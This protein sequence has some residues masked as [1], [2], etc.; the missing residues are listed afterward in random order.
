M[1]VIHEHH[2]RDTACKQ[3]AG[4]TEAAIAAL[5]D[6][7]MDDQANLGRTCTGGVRPAAL[8]KPVR[9]GPVV[10]HA[11][12][13]AEAHDMQRPCLPANARPCEIAT[14]EPSVSSGAVA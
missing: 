12:H 2:G 10:V 13:R 14:T 4:R 7:L 9:D 5:R 8:G 1:T 6:S 11:N 3:Q